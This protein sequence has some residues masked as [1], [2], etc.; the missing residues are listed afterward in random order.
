MTSMMN[1]AMMAGMVK[2]SF[3]RQMYQIVLFMGIGYFFSGF[4][5]AKFPFNLTQKFKTLSQQGISIPL[6]DVSFVSSMSL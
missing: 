6:L 3:S 5:L 2:Q 1:P 4:I